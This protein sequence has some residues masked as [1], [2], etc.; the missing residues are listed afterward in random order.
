MAS[1]PAGTGSCKMTRND[2][3]SLAETFDTE[4]ENALQKVI[5]ILNFPKTTKNDLGY[6]RSQLTAF[7]RRS[8]SIMQEK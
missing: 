1:I 6:K 8:Q 5:P 4:Y 3:T 2:L 7:N